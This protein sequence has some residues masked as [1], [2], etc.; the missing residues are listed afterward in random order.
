MPFCFS[1]SYF[2]LS[3]KVL[4]PIISRPPSFIIIWRVLKSTFATSSSVQPCSPPSASNLLDINLVSIR[5][6]LSALLKSSIA[7]IKPLSSGSIIRPMVMTVSSLFPAVSCTELLESVFLAGTF[8]DELPLVLLPQPV[9]NI[10]AAR[11]IA[12]T[13]FFIVIILLFLLP[14]YQY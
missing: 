14:K 13:S 8:T 9:K 3:P 7:L 11:A 5:Q 2:A 1:S 10:Q 6:P 4:P 12:A